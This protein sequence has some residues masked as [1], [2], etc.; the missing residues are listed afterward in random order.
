LRKKG[1][2]PEVIKEIKAYSFR[3]LELDYIPVTLINTL[4]KL[5]KISSVYPQTLVV[6][7]GND[8]PYNY[9]SILFYAI[10]TNNMNLFNLLV[11]NGFRM[12]MEYIWCE[13]GQSMKI[14]PYAFCSQYRHYHWLDII[15]S[16]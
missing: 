5:L 4:D 9:T 7:S 14:S 8:D 3:K 10:R 13:K 6:K 11:Q 2:P 16:L 15:S 1:L 12:N